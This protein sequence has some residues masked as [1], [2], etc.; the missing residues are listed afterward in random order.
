MIRLHEKGVRRFDFS[1]GDYAYKENFNIGMAPLFDTAVALS[2]GGQ[3]KT[4]RINL[5]AAF[6]K[7]PLMRRLMGKKA[8]V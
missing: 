1:V 8:D 7:S 5:R 2:L 4:A 3:M 6:R